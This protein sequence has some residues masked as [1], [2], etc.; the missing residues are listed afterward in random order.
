VALEGVMLSVVEVGIDRSQIWDDFV[1]KN[2]GNFFQ[3]YS[4]K[5]IFEEV[6]GI[7][8][9]YLAVFH[10]SQ[11]IALLPLGLIPKFSKKNKTAISLPYCPYGGLVT[12]GSFSHNLI[13]DAVLNF[14]EC[15][16]IRR[17]E[18]REMCTRDKFSSSGLVTLMLPLPN[19]SDILWSK[20]HSKVRNQIRKSQKYQLEC[21]WGKDQINELYDV[22]AKNMGRLG[23]PVHDKRFFQLIINEFGGF[24]DILT[25]R[26]HGVVIAGMLVI[27]DKSC[28][29]PLVAS[30]LID[31]NFM[32]A[33]MLMYWEAINCAVKDKAST[34]DFGRSFIGSG[35][36]NFKKQW[37]CFIVPLE[38]KA[39]RNGKIIISSYSNFY[40]SRK[41]KFLAKGWSLLPYYIQLFLG[42]K[43]RKFIP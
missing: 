7:Q 5:G 4:W 34:F 25:L 15:K 22:Y 37:G 30:C 12:S 2:E 14:L 35:T 8:T 39:Y 38:Y 23:T 18:L 32:N 26:R 6:Y 20:L 16:G 41:A 33:N 28:W 11:L 1:R 31:F 3:Y 19:N 40:R 13:I 27:K 42:P 24:S 36:F 10:E 9:L 21:R 43:L 17:L 29:T